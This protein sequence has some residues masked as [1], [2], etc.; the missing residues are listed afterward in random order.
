MQHQ[1][2]VKR[3]FSF[4]PLFFF[5]SFSVLVCS[6]H[7]DFSSPFAKLAAS[8]HPRPHP[9][10][11]SK[12]CSQHLDYQACCA[13]I[14]HWRAQSSRRVERKCGADWETKNE[15]AAWLGTA[16]WKRD[17]LSTVFKQ[18]QGASASG[19]NLDQK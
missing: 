11:T 5:L 7:L 15:D 6:S 2:L 3:H 10:I 16:L 13:H 4:Y 17:H 14:N 8:P 19:I 12:L 1:G 18:P 9:H